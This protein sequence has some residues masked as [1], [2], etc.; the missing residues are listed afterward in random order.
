MRIMIF[1]AL[2]ALGLVAGCSPSAPPPPAAAQI[3]DSV[4]GTV[5]LRDPHALGNHARVDLRVVDV[6]NPSTPLAQV[7]I[8]N[9]SRPP[10]AF[11]MPIDPAQV[12]P[13]RTYAVDAVL[14]DGE[15]RY[16]P[17]L[18]SPVLTDPKH[19]SNVQIVLTPEPTPAEKLSEASKQAFAQIG[20][21]KS[22]SG[23]S[24]T[25]TSSTAWD[26]F[27]TNGKVKAVRET[28]DLYDDKSN[29][30]GRVS[31]KI[32]YQD[33]KPWVVIKEES[34]GEGQ[35]PFATTKVGWDSNGVLVLKEKF[36]NG[37]TSQVSAED[38]KPLYDHALQALQAAQAK[39]PKH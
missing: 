25:P 20:S 2:L 39:M 34:G 13:K 28:T 9:A 29:P 11:S 24:E 37:Q 5:I 31:M 35:R 32:T 1:P 26:G 18:Q 15:R 30:I 23:T 22:I 6:A 27:Y 7:E 36:A 8:P 38:A 21:L 4:S 17:V 33:D 12:N 3:A 19:T 16:L 10:I 14:T